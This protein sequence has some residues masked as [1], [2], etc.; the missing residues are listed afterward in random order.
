M[1]VYGQISCIC[2]HANEGGESKTKDSV[3]N[4]HLNFRSFFSG[5]K[6]ALYTGKY[7]IQLVWYILKQKLLFTLVSVNSGGYLACHFMARQISTTIH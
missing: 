7:G 3:Y 5:K 1:I 4:T 2:L 6:C